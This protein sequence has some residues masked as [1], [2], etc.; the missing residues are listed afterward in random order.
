MPE[1][2][3]RLR[4]LNQWAKHMV[5]LATGNATEG[6]P[7]STKDAAAQSLGRATLCV[8]HSITRHYANQAMLR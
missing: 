4:D 8:D 3:K 5:D 2:P 7:D 1:H 6:G